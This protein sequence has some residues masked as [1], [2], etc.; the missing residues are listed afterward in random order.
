MGTLTSFAGLLE[1]PVLDKPE[2]YHIPKVLV[3]FSQRNRAVPSDSFVCF[4]ENDI[5]FRDVLTAATDYVDELK[6][7]S[8]VISPDCSLY[9]KY[10]FAFRSQ[11]SI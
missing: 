2:E 9:W 5:L 6:Q 3:P 11:I 8:G 7:F 10:P 4:Y 1:I